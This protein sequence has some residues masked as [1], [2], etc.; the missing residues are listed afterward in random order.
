MTQYTRR[1]DNA[2]HAAQQSRNQM[3]LLC[4]PLRISARSAVK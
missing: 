1:G 4:V 2:E 3:F